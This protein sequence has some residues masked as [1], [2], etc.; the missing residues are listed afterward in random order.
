MDYQKD[1]CSSSWYMDAPDNGHAWGIEYLNID[2][3]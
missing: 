3:V 1:E 2:F